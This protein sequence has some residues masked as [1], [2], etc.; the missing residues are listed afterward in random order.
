MRI[1][2]TGSNCRVMRLEEIDFFPSLYGCHANQNRPFPAAR[3]KF[4][5]TEYAND[6]LIIFVKQHKL[7][8]HSVL[9]QSGE[10]TN[11]LSALGKANDEI[12]CFY[13]KRDFRWGER[14]I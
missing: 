7:V 14:G 3:A 5:R 6:L 12:G 1:A 10:T 11:S 4:I 2:Y 13:L 8:F 9:I